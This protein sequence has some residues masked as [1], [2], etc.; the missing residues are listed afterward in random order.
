MPQPQRTRS[1]PRRE[2][3]RTALIEAAES[4]FAEAGVEGV[5]NRQI[6]TAIGSLHKNVIGYHFGSKEA[7][8]EAIYHYRLP[9]LDERRAILLAKAD[10]A[11]KGHEVATLMDIAWRPLLEQTN[12]A[13]KHSFAGF[14]SE[15]SR[16]GWAWTRTVLNPEYPVTNEVAAR[17][18]ACLPAETAARFNERM[19]MIGGMIFVSLQ[20]IDREGFGRQKADKVF[21]EAVIMASA[22]LMAP[23]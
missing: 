16:T 8:M 23:V 17:L 19:H 9:S 10:A 15:L 21:G 22:A 3:T 12:G 14:L 20:L 2:A 7:L 13:G 6:G 11:R 18:R 1:D 4:M 5:S